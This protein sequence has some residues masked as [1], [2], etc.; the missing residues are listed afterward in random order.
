MEAMEAMGHIM[1]KGTATNDGK[2]NNDVP[3]KKNTM[4]TKPT[5]EKCGPRGG[6][7]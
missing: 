2:K 3:N 7:D 6:W 4:T 1:G 5:T